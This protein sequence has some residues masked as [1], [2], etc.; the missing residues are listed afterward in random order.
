MLARAESAENRETAERAL[1]VASVYAAYQA[2][3]SARGDVDYGDLIMKVVELLRSEPAVT[4]ELR[5]RYP[6]ILVDEFQDINIAMGTL[7]REFA[8]RNG[9]IWAVGDV[10][11]A[12]YRFRGGSPSN[13]LNFMRDY[14]HARVITLAK[15]YR[16]RPPILRAADAFASA[17]LPAEARIA[18]QPMRSEA[19]G[20]EAVVTLALAPN[21]DRR[22]RWAGAAD[23][24]AG[25]RWHPAAR[26][27]GVAADTRSRQAGLRG[28]ATARDS[29]AIC[30]AAL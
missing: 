2:E 8:G 23:A 26:T 11:Q 30:R 21:A 14:D 19:S 1:E 28:A 6:H 10:D 7:L 3:L 4:E 16:S 27:G 12:I 20:G 5:Q 17:Y 18:S 9:A 22:T 24:R 15:N 13:M 25:G 29:S